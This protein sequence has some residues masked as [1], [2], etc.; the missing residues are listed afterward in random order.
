MKR[1]KADKYHLPLNVTYII[2]FPLGPHGE[3]Y[4]NRA[5]RR[6]AAAIARA[7]KWAA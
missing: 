2:E 3:P 6:R 7:H 1:F 4:P 5:E